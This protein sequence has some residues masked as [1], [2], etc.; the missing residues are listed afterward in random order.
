MFCLKKVF[1]EERFVLLGRF[2]PL[3]ILSIAR[4][5]CKTFCTVQSV[6]LFVAERFVCREKVKLLTKYKNY[7][8][9]PKK[10]YTWVSDNCSALN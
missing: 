2:N 9:N 6:G 3:E 1:S 5:V 10:F 7:F 8:K 4:F